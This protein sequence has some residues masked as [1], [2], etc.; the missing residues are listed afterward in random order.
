MSDFDQTPDLTGALVELT[1]PDGTVYQFQYSAIIEY[2]E[3]DYVVLVE[4]EQDGEG[5]DQLLITR[6][7]ESEEGELSFEVVEEEDII[8][9]VFEK[10]VAQSL[11]GVLDEDESEECDCGHCHHEHKHDCDCGHE[12]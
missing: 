1:A 2:A 11:A 4:M 5:N 3:Q 6:L 12:H 8:S 9:A 7:N 10:Y